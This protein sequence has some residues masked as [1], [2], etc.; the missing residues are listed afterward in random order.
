[1]SNSFTNRYSYARLGDDFYAEVPIQAMNN[2]QLLMFN[3][4]LFAELVV[5][6][7]NV[8]G[9][10]WLKQLLALAKPEQN[11]FLAMAYAGHQFGHF[12]MLGD[13]R[14]CLVAEAEHNKGQLL[15]LHLK[16]SGPTPFARS[17]DGNAV[18]GP[19]A[20]EY[21]ISEAIH[22]LAIP[23][24][25]SLAVITTGNTVN[26]ETPQAGAML[27]RVAQSHLRVGTF[28]Y[29]AAL[30]EGQGLAGLFKYTAERLYP[31]VL[32]AD[33]PALA[34]LEQVQ[35][36]QIE[37]VC[38]W[39]RVGFIH[40][41][42]NTDNTAISGETI[43][44][45]PCAF[46]DEYHP[47]TVFSSIDRH[48]RYAFS[49]QSNIIFWNLCRLAESLL[50]LI[51]KEPE[52]AIEQAMAVIKSGQTAYQTQYSSMMAAKIGFEYANEQTALLI[53][54]LLDCMQSQR[55]DYTNTFLSLAA[56]LSDASAELPPVLVAWAS[57]WKEALLN[58]SKPEPCLE[59]MYQSNP[60]VI[61]RNHLVEQALVA[62]SEDNPEPFNI[63]KA[64]LETPYQKKGG[65][66]F[67]QKPPSE[68]ERVLATSCG[69]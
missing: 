50:P 37:L 66:N 63:L 41:V 67:F 36:K 39:Q 24:T 26:R 6:Q 17:G 19:M 31:D 61:P 69:T 60:Q 20:R 23:T 65:D 57:D 35:A 58:H 33:N 68:Q 53:A 11:N 15:D 62:L 56:H 34:L 48:G 12:T 29:A 43:D 16:G 44:Y 18:L 1:M 25:R 38:N 4:A 40:G 30:N 47:D 55:L 22:A 52:I 13:G 10:D 5:S 2:Y 54:E 7:K 9:A 51:N 46:M 8:S 59:R 42:M 28:E 49:N 21:L 32:Q 45:G 3:D 27:L 64:R 14:A